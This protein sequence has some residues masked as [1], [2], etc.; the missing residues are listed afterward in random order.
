M[1]LDPER[2][3]DARKRAVRLAAEAADH[4]DLANAAR[5]QVERLARTWGF[6][7]GEVLDKPKPSA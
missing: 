6:S 2:V 5:A 7:A 1:N 3:E 4:Q